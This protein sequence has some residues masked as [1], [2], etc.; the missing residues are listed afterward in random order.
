[1]IRE[2]CRMKPQHD[3]SPCRRKVPPCHW[4]ETL[5]VLPSIDD[6]LLDRV[7][8][9]LSP[10]RFSDTQIAML[11]DSLQEMLGAERSAPKRAG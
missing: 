8:S 11:R 9:R 10:Q 5:P 3:A 1:M 6:A 7:W 2:T 4:G